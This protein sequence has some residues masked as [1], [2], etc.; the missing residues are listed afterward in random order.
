MPEVIIIGE[1]DQAKP[2]HDRD[3]GTRG[4]RRKVETEEL[5]RCPVPGNG[6]SRQ[7]L[8]DGSTDPEVQ[9]RNEASRLARLRGLT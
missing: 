7:V 5:A 9:A 8:W 6:L 1:K 4:E 2:A 3:F